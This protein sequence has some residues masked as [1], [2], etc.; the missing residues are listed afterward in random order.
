MARSRLPGEAGAARPC[1]AMAGGRSRSAQHGRRT[2]P[3][4][5]PVERGRG[6]GAPVPGRRPPLPPGRQP[7]NAQPLLAPGRAALLPPLDPSAPS[8][9]LHWRLGVV[10]VLV[11]PELNRSAAASAASQCPTSGVDWRYAAAGP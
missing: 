10:T 5:T 11:M 4:W 1:G 2:A 9:A 3:C 8:L 6:Q 7:S